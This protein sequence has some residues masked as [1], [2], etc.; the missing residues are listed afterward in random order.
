MRFDSEYCAEVRI[1]VVYRT[2]ARN[3][4]WRALSVSAVISYVDRQAEILD[5]ATKIDLVVSY[6]TWQLTWYLII[7]E[8]KLISDS[9]SR[10]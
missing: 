6:L 1:G 3:K 9:F 8:R 10:F 5:E 7:C 4:L 2:G